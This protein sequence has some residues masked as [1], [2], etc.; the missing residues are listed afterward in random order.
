[1]V[2][3]V[4]IKLIRNNQKCKWILLTRKQKKYINER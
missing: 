1:M 4:K 3:Q 2:L